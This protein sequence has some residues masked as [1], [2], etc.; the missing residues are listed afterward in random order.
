VS[1]QGKV[2]FAIVDEIP[3]LDSAVEMNP[4]GHKAILLHDSRIV[5]VIFV[6]YT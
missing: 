1:T 2:P 5:S 4:V 6:W 3:K